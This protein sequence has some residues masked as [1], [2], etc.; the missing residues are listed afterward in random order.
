MLAKVVEGLCV[1]SGKVTQAEAEF[2]Y[3]VYT[4]VS[5]AA[6]CLVAL[7]VVEV[8]QPGGEDPPIAALLRRLGDKHRYAEREIL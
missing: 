6:D 8:V 1:A 4:Y 3:I 5:H 2:A 7:V